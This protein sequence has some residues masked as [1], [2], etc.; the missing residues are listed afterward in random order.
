M[1]RDRS[2]DANLVAWGQRLGVTAG[3][4]APGGGGGGGMGARV[5]G[6]MG[7]RCWLQVGWAAI[8]LL[9]GRQASEQRAAS[10]E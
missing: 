10:S 8:H 3:W 9:S 4:W 5:Q 6:C 7:A 2:T 1:I